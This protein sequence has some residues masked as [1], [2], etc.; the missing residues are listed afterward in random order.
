ME[1]EGRR[2]WREV[3]RKSIDRE[4]GTPQ[5]FREEY[6]QILTQAFTF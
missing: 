4:I 5:G 3:A 1:E 6:N 2:D